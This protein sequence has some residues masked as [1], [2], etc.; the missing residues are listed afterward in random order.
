MSDTH[1]KYICLINTEE[2]Y[3]LWFAWKAIPDGWKQVGPTGSKEECLEYIKKVWTD[4]RPKSLREK[5][6]QLTA[7]NET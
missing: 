4:M 7:A 6:D 5:M 3:S 1:E 2:Q